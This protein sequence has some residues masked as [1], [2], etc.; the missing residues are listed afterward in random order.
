MS[1][2]FIR[3]FLE[4]FYL[5]SPQLVIL[6]LVDFY[7]I[8]KPAEVYVISMAKV[9]KLYSYYF[10]SDHLRFIT[11]EYYTKSNQLWTSFKSVRFSAGY[12]CILVPKSASVFIFGT[13]AGN[14][15][16]SIT[17]AL[18]HCTVGAVEELP[19][20]ANSSHLK[21]LN[22]VEH[23]AA[24]SS[25]CWRCCCCHYCCCWMLPLAVVKCE[26]RKE[27]CYTNCIQEC[28]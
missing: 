13:T 2:P 18:P 7:I 8:K 1:Y 26:W 6:K 15:T 21:P 5:T 22:V 12:N 17:Q 16:Y 9:F 19:A 11:P 27:L 4:V 14:A 25:H 24:C 28:V 3:K 10:I 23:P 20:T